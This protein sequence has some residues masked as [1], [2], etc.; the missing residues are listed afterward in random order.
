MGV[1]SARW[2]AYAGVGASQ[3]Q[4]AVRRSPLATTTTTYGATV[5]IA[6]RNRR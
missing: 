4:G 2:V 3:L 5:G 6:Y 1:V